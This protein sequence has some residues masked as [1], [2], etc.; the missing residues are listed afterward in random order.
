MTAFT[1]VLVIYLPC[2]CECVCNFLSVCLSARVHLVRPDQSYSFRS[3]LLW[4]QTA[5]NLNAVIDTAVA[6]ETFFQAL[7]AKY[8]LSLREREK[9][10]TRST[11]IQVEM[12]RVSDKM[13]PFENRSGK[14]PR[15]ERSFH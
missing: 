14:N 15:V 6:S 10:T 9:T 8:I 11:V 4:V 7:K 1:L 3:W 13:R 5:L 2:V 12:C